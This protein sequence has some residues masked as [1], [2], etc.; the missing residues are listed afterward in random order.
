MAQTVQDNPA[1]GQGVAGLLETVR[2]RK[3]LAVVPFLIVLA[4]AASL[5]FFLPSLWTSR[6]VIMVDRQQIPE[7]FVKPTVTSEL[8]SRLLTLSQ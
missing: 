1:R 8:E 2:R 3:A 5:A 7:A 6:A 4:A